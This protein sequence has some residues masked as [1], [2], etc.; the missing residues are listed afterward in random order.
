MT[1]IVGLIEDG[2]IYMGGDSAE[3]SGCELKIIKDAKVFKK[4]DFLFG[5]S[6]EPRIH[7]IIKYIFEIPKDCGEFKDIPYRDPLAY[8]NIEFVPEL[9]QY[10]KEN[11]IDLSEEGDDFR[12]L[13][14]YKGRLFRI[15]ADFYVGENSKPYD[16]IGCGAAEAFGSLYTIY[17]LDELIDTTWVDPEIRILTALE[18]S[19]DV[20]CHVR[21]PFRVINSKEEQV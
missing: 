10:L 6:G 9:K 18:A 19:E 1:C 15:E 11:D 5:V 12:I 3:S 20:N 8:M 17:A 16:C 14:G 2:I 7:N 21:R 13:V 4:G